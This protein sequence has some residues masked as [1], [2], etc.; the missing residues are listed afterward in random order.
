MLGCV[1][2]TRHRFLG[3]GLDN[4]S[5]EPFTIRSQSRKTLMVRSCESI[6]A[7]RERAGLEREGE[8]EGGDTRWQATVGSNVVAK[9]TVSTPQIPGEEAQLVKHRKMH[10]GILRP[11]SP[12]HI[13]AVL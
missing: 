11:L 10:A 3:I 5:Q 6:S 4:L 13:H 7:M 8:G 2:I 9:S 1:Q 12:L